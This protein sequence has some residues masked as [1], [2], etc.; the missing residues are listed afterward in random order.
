MNL[1]S[2]EPVDA[3]A[4]IAAEFDDPV[5]GVA[6]TPGPQR[7]PAIAMRVVARVEVDGDRL[8]DGHVVISVC[9]VEGGRAVASVGFAHLLAF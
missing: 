6:K 9:A 8:D 1:D 7:C 3:T 2:K 5:S 4:A